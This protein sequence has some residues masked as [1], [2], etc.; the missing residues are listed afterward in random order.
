MLTASS[1]KTCRKCDSEKSPDDFYRDATAKDGRHTLCKSCHNA[2][3]KRWVRAN[4]EKR[5][6][7]KK[8]DYA[9]HGDAVRARNKRWYERNRESVA[10]RTSRNAKQNAPAVRDA[11]FRREYG[12]SL[13][14]VEAMREAQGGVC[15]ICRSPQRAGKK[16]LCV[17]HCHTT[18]RVRGL[19]C[20]K[21]NRGIGLFGDAPANFRAAITYLGGE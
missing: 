4:P 12:I 3:A 9:R 15:A 8:T 7:Y 21:C 6:E 1:T 10:F 17:D 5:R 20:H 14:E 16:G 11:R 13:A 2:A 19:L 18:G